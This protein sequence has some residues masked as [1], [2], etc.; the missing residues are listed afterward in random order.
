MK[1][2]RFL[3]STLTGH[4][5]LLALERPMVSLSLRVAKSGN[6][7]RGVFIVFTDRFPSW[8]TPGGAG[9]SAVQ[10]FQ[11][12]AEDFFDDLFGV[13][14]GLDDLSRGAAVFLVITVDVLESLGCFR[15]CREPKHPFTIGKVGVLPC[16]LHH[17]GLAAGQVTER[18]VTNPAVCELH[19]RTLGATEFAARLLNVRLVQ[20]RRGRDFARVTD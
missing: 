10:S 2:G 17:H 4:P 14:K 20:L 18:A 5:L 7:D 8:A 13:E 11:R 3:L 12:V 15:G 6:S 1:R 19:A 16:V 9:T